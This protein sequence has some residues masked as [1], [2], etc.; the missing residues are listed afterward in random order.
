MRLQKLDQK[1]PY[2][3]HLMLLAHSGETQVRNPTTLG[4]PHQA[5]HILELGVTVLAHSRQ[6]KEPASQA[7]LDKPVQPVHQ[8]ST[9]QWIL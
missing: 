9:T 2:K 6:G 5:G 1:E 7:V 4:A 3:V 8:P